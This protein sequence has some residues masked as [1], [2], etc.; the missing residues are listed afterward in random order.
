MVKSFICCST[1]HLCGL[2][3]G[4]S[5]FGSSVSETLPQ[6][7]AIGT[8]NLLF[9][10]NEQGHTPACLSMKTLLSD[11]AGQMNGRRVYVY[12]EP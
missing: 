2:K 5:D 4:L 11:C 8:K 1:R 3:F 10:F 7:G 6:N 9:L 12:I